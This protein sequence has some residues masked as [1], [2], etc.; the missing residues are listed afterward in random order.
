MGLEA[1]RCD[2]DRPVER[3]DG[4][5][6]AADSKQRFGQVAVVQLD[7]GLPGY[8]SFQDGECLGLASLTEQGDRLQPVAAN[9][10][11]HDGCELPA[12]SSGEVTLVPEVP[13]L[14]ALFEY[15]VD[16]LAVDVL[17]QAGFVH[18][19]VESREQI[20]HGIVPDVGAPL[21]GLFFSGECGL[22]QDLRHEQGR[23]IDLVG[24]QLERLGVSQVR[25]VDEGIGGI[26][27]LGGRCGGSLT[28]NESVQGPCHPEQKR[29]FRISQPRVL[30]LLHAVTVIVGTQVEVVVV[31]DVVPSFVEDHDVGSFFGDQQGHLDDGLRGGV[32]GDTV[33]DDR[34]GVAQLAL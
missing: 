29:N 31:A 17:I 5:V 19:G 15:L 21:S 32:S 34:V 22:V 13:R 1:G 10:L 11:D 2:L 27:D 30:V 16:H 25:A 23:G 18:E 3:G 28:K 6:H 33:V 8:D 26:K 4:L 12:A 9:V 20:Q 24:Q 14:P 7:I